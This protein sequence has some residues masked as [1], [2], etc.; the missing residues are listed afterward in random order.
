MPYRGGLEPYGFGIGQCLVVLPDLPPQFG[1]LPC[2][3]PC[4]P[5]HKPGGQSAIQFPSHR[6]RRDGPRRNDLR[7][8]PRGLHK[9]PLLFRKQPAYVHAHVF[10]DLGGLDSQLPCYGGDIPS[11]IPHAPYP[12]VEPHPFPVSGSAH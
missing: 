4:G 5:A 3:C 6:L 8:L 12:V 7:H 11:G 1:I 2:Q 9:L 10:V